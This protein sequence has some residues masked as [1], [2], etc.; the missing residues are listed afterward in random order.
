MSVYANVICH[1]CKQQLFLGKI[2]SNKF[3]SGQSVVYFHRGAGDRHNF[4][5]PELNKALWKFLAEHV[6]HRIA[7]LSEGEMTDDVC[8]YQEIGGHDQTDVSF[9][10]YLFNWPTDQ[11]DVKIKE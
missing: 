11:I 6:D 4:D 7:C 10:D 3:R 2:C 1:T 8:G 5:Q 9:K